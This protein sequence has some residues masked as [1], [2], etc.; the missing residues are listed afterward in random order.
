MELTLFDTLRPVLARVIA[1]LVAALGVYLFEKLHFTL[2]PEA[3]ASLSG[4]VL[5]VLYSAIHKLINRKVNPGDAA[6][7]T[8]SKIEKV[9]RSNLDTVKE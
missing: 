1:G 4:A 8:I 9:E 6:S 7:V 2:G 5:L 3:E